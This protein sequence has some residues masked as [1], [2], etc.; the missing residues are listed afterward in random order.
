MPTV[1]SGIAFGYLYLRVGLWASIV[2]HFLI[3]YI[4]VTAAILGEWLP[5]L[6]TAYYLVFFFLVM[7]G[8]V[9]MVHYAVIMVTEGREA[10]RRALAEE[11]PPMPAG[12]DGNP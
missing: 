7:V 2:L 8:F 12:P 6:E 11:D 10:V 4:N 1:V 3:D 9:V 5:G